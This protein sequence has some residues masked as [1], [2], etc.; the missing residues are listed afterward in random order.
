MDGHSMSRTQARQVWALR[1][2]LPQ[3]ARSRFDALEIGVQVQL[4]EVYTE[5]WSG[6]TSH[7]S[8][9]RRA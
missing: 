1:L 4:A 9:E 2:G 5:V 3:E 7:A 6:G 8:G